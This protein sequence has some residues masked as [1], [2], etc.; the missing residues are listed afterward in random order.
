M[1]PMIP[2][3][4]DDGYLPPGIHSATLDEIEKRFGRESEVRQAE[5]QSLQWLIDLVRRVGGL[6]VIVN[7]SFVTDKFEPNDVDCV[8]LI[9]EHFPHDVSAEMELDEGLP[10]L[11]FQL[12]YAPDFEVMVNDV[13]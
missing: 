5:M 11:Q 4:N 8:V 3:F 7:G 10:F 9:D 12:L 2:D 13:Y 1:N 6:R